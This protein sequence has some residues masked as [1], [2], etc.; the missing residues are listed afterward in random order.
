V[1]KHTF[2]VGKHTSVLICMQLLATTIILSLLTRDLFVVD[3]NILVVVIDI[4]M[5][6]A[7][8]T[9]RRAGSSRFL[10]YYF[11]IL[12]VLR[13]GATIR[14]PKILAPFPEN[15]LHK[16]GRLLEKIWVDYTVVRQIMAGFETV[17]DAFE[18]FDSLHKRKTFRTR[19][20]K[21]E[22]VSAANPTLLPAS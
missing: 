17:H 5:V 2:S 3:G 1:K 12:K 18:F 4:V 11:P 10:K 6:M 14:Y 21:I 16:S 20:T 13:N 9:W 15:Q 7:E 22:H 8:D 19:R